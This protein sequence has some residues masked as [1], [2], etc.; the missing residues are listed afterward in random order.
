MGEILPFGKYEG[1]HL[2]IALTGLLGV[3]MAFL[4]ARKL[5]GS[6]AGFFAALMLALTP[7]YYGHSFINGKDLPVAAFYLVAVYAL[8]VLYEHLPRP[9]KKRIALTGAALALPI[10][11][12]VGSI[13][14]FGYVVVLAIAWILAERFKPE[15]S[16]SKEG[17]QLRS[18]AISIVAMW[19]V[20][21]VIMVIW[22]PFAQVNPI[23]N[24][25]YAIVKSAT[26]NGAGFT[27]LFRGQYIFSNVMPREYLPVLLLVTLPEFYFAGLLAY[28]AGGARRVIGGAA[29]DAPAIDRI[30][31]LGFFT[32]VAIFPIAVAVALR[33]TVYD[34]TRL[35]LF[36]IPPLTVITAIGLDWFFSL[37]I[38]SI[39]KAAVAALL[40]ID[41]GLVVR[42]MIALHP[43]QYAF[44]NRASGGTSGAY[45]RYDVEYWGT[46]YK[47]GIEWLEKNYMPHA[48]PHSITV[49]NPSNPFLTYYYLHTSKPEVQRFKPLDSADRAQIVLS[50]TRWNQHLVYGRKPIHIVEREGVPFLY[51]YE[52][53]AEHEAADSAMRWGINRMYSRRDPR[54]AQE[55]FRK[56]LSLEPDH[57]G[58][59]QAL[60]LA[61]DETGQSNESRPIWERVLAM[62]KQFNDSRTAELAEERIAA[63]R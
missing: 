47:E 46:S 57:Y 8:L 40:V 56:V 35:F 54:A 10:S 18:I 12:R 26:F 62:A 11:V 5:A 34:S 31:K 3:L 39:V 38:Q 55:A 19:A 2:M 17:N 27:N 16:R 32:F 49:A 60:A 7:V 9:G 14:V 63:P 58:A 15:P 45:R 28:L 25:I 13:M 42:D 41:A 51:I 48:A 22:W 36:V 1:I 50:L 44:F 23:M 53:P 24:P 43:Y 4:T 30:A 29:M 6:R 21:W 59:L 33:P 61:L 52:E 37:R 20:A